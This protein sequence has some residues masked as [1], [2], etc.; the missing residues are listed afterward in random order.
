MSK[1]TPR[2]RGKDAV[3]AA[4]SNPTL[5]RIETLMSIYQLNEN[6]DPDK[7]S[8]QNTEEVRLRR[9]M[10]SLDLGSLLNALTF[11]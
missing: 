11:T 10:G 2:K 9:R 8:V 5:D 7:I 3:Q 4:S 1:P 6:E